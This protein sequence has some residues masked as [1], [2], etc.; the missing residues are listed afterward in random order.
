VR[1]AAE[2][3]PAPA[4]PAG[5]ALVRR[6]RSGR[7]MLGYTAA[8][9]AVSMMICLTVL[10][11]LPSLIGWQTLVIKS[12]SMAPRLQVGDTVVVDRSGSAAAL[13]GKIVTFHDPGG[14]RGLITHRILY[15]NPDGTFTTKGDANP[16]ADGAP[17]P[18]SLIVGR[19]RMMVPLVGKPTVWVMHHAYAPLLATAGALFLLVMTVSRREPAVLDEA[20][21]LVVELPETAPVP[22]SASVAH[23]AAP[24]PAPLPAPVA[25]A[26]APRRLAPPA[27]PVGRRMAPPA[28]RRER[29]S[30]GRGRHSG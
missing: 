18:P 15:R 4:R 10:T 9:F 25:V 5:A 27:A 23:V 19:P 21:P 7:R 11:F 14:D 3:T 1:H 30:A 2:A 6:A 24:V 13:A 22:A 20:G 26:A 8:L 29:A 12:G 17:L 28:A 16:T